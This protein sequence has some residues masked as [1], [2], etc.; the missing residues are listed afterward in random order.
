MQIN[1]SNYYIGIYKLFKFIIS[2]CMCVHI[3]GCFWFFTAKLENFTPETWVVKY[4]YYDESEGTQY[5][6]AIYW[7]FT[8]VTTVGYGDIA[9]GSELE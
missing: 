5:L 6:A 3:M 1:S 4:G 2:V 7:A 9:A 8:T